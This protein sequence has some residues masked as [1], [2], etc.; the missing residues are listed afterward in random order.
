MNKQYLTKEQIE[1]ASIEE[2]ENNVKA[3][4][5]ELDQLKES[6]ETEEEKERF[7]ELVHLK[8][9]SNIRMNLIEF[10]NMVWKNKDKS[11]R[12]DNEEE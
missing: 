8:I 3:L 5:E 9:L 7:R 2:L 1:E 11:K 6:L 10:S 4:K 12:G